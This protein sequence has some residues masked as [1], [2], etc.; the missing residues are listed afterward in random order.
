M[1]VFLC[2]IL[3]IAVLC[4]HT[5]D[6]LKYG[7]VTHV[8]IRYIRIEN[9]RNFRD[10]EMTFHEKANYLVGENAIGKSSFLRLLKLMSEGC[11]ITA[12]RQR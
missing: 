3:Y 5:Q 7:Q 1:F 11:G 4:W 8:Y 6:N 2:R 10:V 12:P 9:Y